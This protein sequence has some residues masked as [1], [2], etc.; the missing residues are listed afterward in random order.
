MQVNFTRRFL[1]AVPLAAYRAQLWFLG[2]ALLV[3]GYADVAW[4]EVPI[5]SAPQVSASGY[6]LLEAN[7]GKI[8][9]SEKP[10]ARLEPASLTKIMTAYS[11]FRE[12]HEGNV[13]LNDLVLISEKAWRSMGSRSFVEVGNRIPLEVLIKGMI[14]QSGNDASIALAEHIAGSEE[15]FSELMNSHAKRL[16]MTNSH[17]VNVTGLP[18]PNHYSTPAD[19]AKVSYATIREFPEYYAWYSLKEFTW[20]KIKQHNRNGLLWKDEHVDGIK[21]GHTEGAG[22]CLAAAAKDGD[23]RLVSIIMGSS[24]T[25]AREQATLSLLS[26][27]MRFYETRKL[28]PAGEQV[29][30]LRVWGGVEKLLPVGAGDALFIT[31]PRNQTDRMVTEVQLNPDV[32]APIAKGQVLGQVNVT[33]DGKTIATPPLVALQD[34]PEGGF[35]RRLIDKILRWFR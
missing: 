19:L 10:D 15:T 8:L 34:M 4:A 2:T 17:F 20:N 18:D 31:V 27:G 7:S 1:N 13:K 23:M 16:G 3:L 30:Q 22:Y 24:S 35:F 26:Y 6:I 25:K 33:I 32:Y 5:P 12:L 28:Y 14:I 11:V 29:Q 21:T 9:A